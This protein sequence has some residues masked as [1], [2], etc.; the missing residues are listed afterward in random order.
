MELAL[1][2]HSVVQ[3][4]VVQVREDV[5][6]E[7]RLV[8]YVV[9][10]QE[11]FSPVSVW[12]SF[13]KEKLPE[14]MVPGS[15]VVL[16]SLPLTPNGKIDRKALPA[17]DTARPE[18][19]E[20]HV[21]PRTEMERSLATVWQALLPVEQVGI[22]DNFFDLGGHSLLMIQVQSKLQEVFNSSISIIDLFKYP[23]INS[24]AVYLSQEQREQPSVQETYDR[25]ESR[26]VS[27]RRQRQLRQKHR[28]TKL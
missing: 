20:E 8:A 6:G 7:K 2:E 9:V 15:F 27:A 19:D 18:L 21:V 3:E 22:H 23:T 24:L 17:P 4:T 11:L 13:L 16:E 12:R 26:S 25:V 10:N 28:T 14:Y 1:L 5:I